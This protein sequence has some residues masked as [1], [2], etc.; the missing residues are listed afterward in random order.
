MTRSS[1]ASQGLVTA[2]IS[3]F[4][5]AIPIP[6]LHGR[7]VKGFRFDKE[8]DMD[9]SLSHFVDLKAQRHG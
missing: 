2:S 7:I 6:V 5:T 9:W 4:A 1:R 8:P 3:I